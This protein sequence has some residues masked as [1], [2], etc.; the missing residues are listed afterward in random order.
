GPEAVEGA[1][2]NV[3]PALLAASGQR[4]R[5]AGAARPGVRVVVVDN[6]DSFTF[7]LVQYLLELGAI[8]DVY[9]N[10]AVDAAAIFADRPSHI[11]LSPGPGRPDESGVCQAICRAVLGDPIPTLGVCLGHQTLGEV[12]GATVERAG[13]I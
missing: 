13:R 9:R 10:D 5:P 3:L 11:L 12:W 7:N 2:N 4:L 6:Y 1:S 8:V